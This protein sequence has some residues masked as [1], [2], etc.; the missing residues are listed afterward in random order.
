MSE[1]LGK[2]L[3]GIPVAVS[4]NTKTDCV[5][6]GRGVLTAGMQHPD[7]TVRVFLK[8]GKPMASVE[9][10]RALIELVAPFGTK[11]EQE[12][13]PGLVLKAVANSMN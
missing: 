5:Y 8:D 6:L 11:E 10:K 3:S 9:S 12:L 13:F 1:E 2:M 7:V 4:E